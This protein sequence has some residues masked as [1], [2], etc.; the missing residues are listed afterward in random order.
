MSDEGFH[1]IQLNGKQLVFLFMA[2]TV[3]S[4][5]IFLCGVMVGRGVR[6]RAVSA[7]LPHPAEAAAVTGTPGAPGAGDPAT[8]AGAPSEQPPMQAA[9]PPAD[10][11]PPT[12]AEEAGDDD[13]Y[14]HLVKDQK[15]TTLAPKGRG[16]PPAAKTPAKTSEPAKAPEASPTRKAPAPA[17]AHPATAP[18]AVNEPGPRATG[19]A[20]QLV[21]VRERGEADAIAKRLVAKGYQAYV[22]VPEPGKPP[23]YRVQ[24]GRF[25][26]RGDA[27]KV[28]ARL[29]RDEQFKPWVTR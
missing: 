3:V 27:D 17:A 24:V 21:A 1:E 11:T 6:D 18:A 28:A 4:V 16:A 15:D 29:R 9:A 22:L 26:D 14:N 12:P 23:V 20:V 8:T 25:K 19:Y 2:A 13:Y 10:Q 5:V 7:A